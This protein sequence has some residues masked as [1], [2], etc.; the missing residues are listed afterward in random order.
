MI[1]K[2]KIIYIYLQEK[3]LY[4]RTLKKFSKLGIKLE[5]IYNLESIKRHIIDLNEKDS[6]KINNDQWYSSI[7][8]KY[9]LY[10]TVYRF[11][12]TKEIIEKFINIKDQDIIDFGAGK[13][14]FLEFLNLKATGVDI[15]QECVEHMKSIGI[16]AYNIDELD[17]RFDNIFNNAFA[18]EVIE[19]VENQL[20]V[21]NNIYNYIKVNGYLFLSIP[22]LEKSHVLKKQDKIASLKRPENHHIFELDTLDFK[23][24]ITHTKFKMID[25]IH[26]YPHQ[27]Y[28]GVFGKFIDRFFRVDRP[29]WTIFIMRK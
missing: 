4:N 23:N 24:L 20:L 28:G 17:N 16:E 1:S 6:Q 8:N 9:R 13:G 19:H 18:F 12:K 29:K 10:S 21:L 7:K 14:V 22:Y 5:K 2:L 27:L 3:H 25:H 26:I 11:F 15:N